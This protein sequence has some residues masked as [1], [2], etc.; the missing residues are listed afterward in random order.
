MKRNNNLDEKLQQLNED[1][2]WSP[3]R[4]Q[5]IRRKV[6]NKMNRDNK[7]F[8]LVL[9]RWMLP[10]FSLFLLV[11]IVTTLALSE[12]SSQEVA[13]EGRVINSHGNHSAPSTAEDEDTVESDTE[14]TDRPKQ[15]QQ[16]Q[17]QAENSTENSS[18]TNEPNDTGPIEAE[19]NEKQEVTLTQEEIMQVIKGQMNTNLNILLPT[20][21]PLQDGYHLTATT[22]T[23]ATSYTVTFFEHTEPIPINNKLLYS[24]DNPAKVIARLNVQQYAT[25][26]ESDEEIGYEDF[27]ESGGKAIELGSETTGYQ[28]GAAGSVFTSWNVGRWSLAVK[29]RSQEADTGLRYAKDTVDYLTKKALPIPKQHGYAHLDLGNNNTQIKWQKEDTVYTID[30]TTEPNIA[31]MIAVQFN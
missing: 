2:Q 14:Q 10:A 8:P 16:D 29:A 22:S 23:D 1:I 24:D 18:P 13:D 5:R 26:A 4:Q 11:G 19:A 30:Q 12:F 20:E 21:M 28:D 9:K 15:A 25:Q 17:D 6:I 7:I 31:L 3:R 27:T